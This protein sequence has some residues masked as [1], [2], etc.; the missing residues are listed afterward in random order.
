MVS[1]VPSLQRKQNVDNSRKNSQ[2]AVKSIAALDHHKTNI[3]S[4]PNVTR[5]QTMIRAVVH[6]LRYG[7]LKHDATEAKSG[8]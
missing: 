2:F 3:Q 7:S 8:I 5:T 1:L 4:R 6:K